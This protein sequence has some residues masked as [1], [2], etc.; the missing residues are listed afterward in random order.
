MSH[1][2][3]RKKE[4]Q[5]YLRGS[6]YH[7]IKCT[8]ATFLVTFMWRRPLN[9]AVL[10]IA[11]HRKLKRVF[12]ETGT[13]VSMINKCRIKMAQKG[14]YNVRDPQ[15]ERYWTIKESNTIATWEP[16]C[17]KALRAIFK[18][19]SPR[20][21]PRTFFLNKLLLSFSLCHQNLLVCYLI[22]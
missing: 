7:R 20:T 8:A 16:D 17:N 22:H 9:S 15:W 19:Q 18:N 11:T 6:C 12:D 1:E 2:R 5:K 21:N 14:L 10:V 3:M 13:Q 4:T